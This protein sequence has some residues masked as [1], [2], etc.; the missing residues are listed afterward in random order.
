MHIR[1]LE[2]G[3]QAPDAGDRILLSRQPD[4]KFAFNGI[5]QTGAVQAHFADS[6]SFDTLDDA[7]AAGIE[8]AQGRQVVELIVEHPHA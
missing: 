4:G 6:R 7:R 8:W 3:Q 2:P 1:D 5:A